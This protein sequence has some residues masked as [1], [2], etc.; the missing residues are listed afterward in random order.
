LKSV[1]DFASKISADISSLGV[2]AS[3]DSS[4]KSDSRATETISR[5]VFEQDS[6]LVL[7]YLAFLFS[8]VFVLLRHYK[9][10]VRQDQ[11]FEDKQGETNEHEAKDL[12]SHEGNIKSSFDVLGGTKVS[13]S[14]ISGGRYFHADVTAEH[15][16][17]GSN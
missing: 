13:S 1:G 5:N 17:E 3:S 12:S 16:G 8:V 11:D 9:G 6:N 14:Y 15:R 4:E 2:D 7:N 10:L